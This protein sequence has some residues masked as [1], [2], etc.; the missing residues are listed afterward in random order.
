[1]LAV[2][3]PESDPRTHLTLERGIRIGENVEIEA[4]APGKIIIG[5]ETSLQHGCVIRGNISIGAN[6]IFARNV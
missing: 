6:C 2:H 4:V 3:N 5:R 1:M